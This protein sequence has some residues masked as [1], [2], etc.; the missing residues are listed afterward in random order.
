MPTLLQ[1][2]KRLRRDEPPVTHVDQ[3]QPP[4]EASRLL[5]LIPTEGGFAF[6]LFPFADEEA[7]RAYIARHEPQHGAIAFWAL[8][9]ESPASPAVASEGRP[10]PVVLIRDATRTGLVNLYSFVDME[11]VNSFVREEAGNGLD[12][13]N[14]L[15]YWA[16]AVLIDASAWG[17]DGTAIVL[18]AV[19]QTSP[20]PV[21]G[22]APPKPVFR[23]RVAPDAPAQAAHQPDW[24]RVKLPA[25][26][27][28]AATPAAVTPAAKPEDMSAAASPGTGS[29]LGRLVA[30]IQAWPGWDG[31]APLIMRALLLNDET[32][33]D[34]GRDQ[35]DSGR[36]RLIVSLGILA[37]VIGAAGSG[38]ASAIVHL[39]AAALGWGAYAVA[40]YAFGTQ[41][42]RGRRDKDAFTRLLQGLGLASAPAFLL[43]LGIVPVYGPLFVLAAYIWLLL[44]TVAAVMPALELDNQSALVTGTAGCVVLFAV[45]QVMPLLLV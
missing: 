10:E 33:R 21:P 15:V 18:P 11:S 4:E 39:P 34:F 14:V 12:L 44:T 30:D 17:T 25:R 1:T 24:P 31:M 3:E 45:S 36:A 41:A 40:V 22:C 20:S 6:R 27:G 29:T 26:P 23:A 8:Q 13:R 19:T 28:R 7:L 9:S 35:H 32:Y 38:L 43:V 37:A 16:S 5:L 42:F 2:L